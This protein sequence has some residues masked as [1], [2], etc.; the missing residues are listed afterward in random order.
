MDCKRRKLRSP[1]SDKL[2]NE[3]TH[4]PAEPALFDMQ[5]NI[6]MIFGKFSF[7]LSAFGLFGTKASE[8]FP[9]CES[10]LHQM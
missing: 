8:M 3:E 6:S 7:D 5:I 1:V 2:E 9:A 10:F 4:L